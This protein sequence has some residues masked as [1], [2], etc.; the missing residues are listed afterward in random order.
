MTIQ[1]LFLNLFQ[2]ITIQIQGGS[3]LGGAK[4]NPEEQYARY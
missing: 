1:Y 2:L 4:T 3:I